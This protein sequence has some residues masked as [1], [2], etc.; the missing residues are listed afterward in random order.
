MSD[1]WIRQSQ[2]AAEINELR[3]KLKET[4]ARLAKAIELIEYA[5]V[6]DAYR[7]DR[8]YSP[9]TVFGRRCFK[10]LGWSDPHKP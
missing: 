9:T 10:F 3:D 1:C 7:D 8:G 6:S 2:V 5:T 4:E